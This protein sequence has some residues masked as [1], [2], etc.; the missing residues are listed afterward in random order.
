MNG[1]LV[2]ES[3]IARLRSGVFLPSDGCALNDGEP[4]QAEHTNANPLRRHVEPMSAKRQADDE[5]DV[6]DDIYPKRH[7]DHPD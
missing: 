7:H 1:G 2:L 6:A 3:R 5:Y 4:S